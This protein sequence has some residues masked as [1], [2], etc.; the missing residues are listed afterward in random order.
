MQRLTTVYQK[1]AT[2]MTNPSTVHF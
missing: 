1:Y 2:Q